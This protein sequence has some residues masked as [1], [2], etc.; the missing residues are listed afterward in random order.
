MVGIFLVVEGEFCYDKAMINQE[1][2]NHKEFEELEEFSQELIQLGRDIESRL[3][4]KKKIEEEI[5]KLEKQTADLRSQVFRL[6]ERLIKINSELEKLEKRR[7]EI[8]GE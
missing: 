1:E 5:L 3:Q 8:E 2:A 6:K 7:K 4:E